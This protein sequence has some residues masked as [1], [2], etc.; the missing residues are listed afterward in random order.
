MIIHFPA[1]AFDVEVFGSAFGDF[2]IFAWDD[3]VG[4]VAAAGP[5]LAVEAMA[6]GGDCRFAG[7][8]VGD[9]AAHAGAFCHF[10][11]S[12][13]VVVVINKSQ[14]GAMMRFNP[15]N[16]EDGEPL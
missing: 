11:C 9:F 2:K 10:V 4:G 14:I 7:V 8:F 13:V 5:F 6:E 1:I 16:C 12:V 15:D 3:D